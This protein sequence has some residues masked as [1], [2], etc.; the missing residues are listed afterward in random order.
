MLVHPVKFHMELLGEVRE[1]QKLRMEEDSTFKLV[2][3]VM[4]HMELLGEMMGGLKLL[5]KKTNKT[6]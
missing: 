5:V 3:P 2:H 1:W 6:C 4:F